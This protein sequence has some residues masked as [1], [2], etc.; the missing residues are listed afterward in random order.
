MPTEPAQEKYISKS[1]SWSTVPRGHPRAQMRG[2]RG[3]ESRVERKRL[4]S[5]SRR[6]HGAAASQSSKLPAPKCTSKSIDARDHL[7][8]SVA[9][10]TAK[11][12]SGHESKTCFDHPPH[13]EAN[14]AHYRERRMRMRPQKST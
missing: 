13:G 14:L 7:P 9:R 3:S 8:C 4:R 10:C 2:S 1:M 11:D 5:G 6:N 12:R